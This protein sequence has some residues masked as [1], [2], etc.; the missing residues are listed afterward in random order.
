MYK[1]IRQIHSLAACALLL[2]VV[3]YFVTGYVLIHG[4][5]FDRLKPDRIT[6]TETVNQL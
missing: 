5:W 2:F 6:Y 1:I 3:M 4:E